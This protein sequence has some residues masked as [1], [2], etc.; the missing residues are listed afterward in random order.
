MKVR[1]A[2]KLF[3]MGSIAIFFLSLATVIVPVFAVT[4]P[5]YASYSIGGDGEGHSFSVVVNETVSPS[6]AAGMSDFTLQIASAMGNFSYSKIMNASKVVLP[7]FPVISNQSFTYQFHNYTI[8]ATINQSG[9]GS[10]DYNGRTYTLSN[11]TFS[12]TASGHSQ[13]SAIGSASV[14]PSGLVYSVA[15]VANGTDT[16]SVRLLAT[17]LPLVSPSSSSSQTTTSVAVAGGVGS[18]L[19]GVGAFVAYKRKNSSHSGDSGET[20]P[21]YHVD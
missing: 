6:A 14:F 18:I 20:K 21:L 19:V 2:S 7:Y 1:S 12:V 16:V 8:Y 5:Q 17:N 11:Y 4:A 9:T 10:V 3:F 15:L 13:T